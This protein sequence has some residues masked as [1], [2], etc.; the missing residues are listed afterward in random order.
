MPDP[1]S[2]DEK[3]MIIMFGAYSKIKSGSKQHCVCV[4]W[5]TAIQKS[6]ER[7]LLCD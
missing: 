3:E 2:L 6:L 5:R 7:Y 1:L 4:I